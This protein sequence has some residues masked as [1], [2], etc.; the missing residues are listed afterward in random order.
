MTNNVYRKFRDLVG[1]NRLIIGTVQS[2]NAD[3]TSTI[4]TLDGGTIRPR[5]Q[6]VAVNSKAFV[7]AG[8]VEGEAPDLPAYNLIV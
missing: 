8:L 7:R 1:M 5:G 6:S 3:G 4:L 2:H